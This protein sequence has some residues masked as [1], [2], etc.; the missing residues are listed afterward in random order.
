MNHEVHI[1]LKIERYALWFNDIWH[2][3]ENVSLFTFI[4]LNE[5]HFKNK[6]S[7]MLSLQL[8]YDMKWI[9]SV[10]I[11]INGLRIAVGA[12]HW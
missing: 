3:L 12:F 11:S 1:V 8:C 2:E 6:I 4:D 9:E 5:R 10:H 7:S